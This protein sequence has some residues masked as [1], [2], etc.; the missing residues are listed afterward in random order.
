MWVLD[1]DRFREMAGRE[2]V[3]EIAEW[4]GLLGSGVEPRDGRA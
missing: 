2:W 1:G 3:A 4:R